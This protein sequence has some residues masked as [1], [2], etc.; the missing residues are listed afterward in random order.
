MIK[1]T[2]KHVQSECFKIICRQIPMA[3]MINSKY[4]VYL[5]KS[6]KFILQTWERENGSEFTKN[7]RHVAGCMCKQLNMLA[8]IAE[9]KI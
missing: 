1:S 9:Q 8:H 2:V 7:I 3:K 4:P 5:L 6:C